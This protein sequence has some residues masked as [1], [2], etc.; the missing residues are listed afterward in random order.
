[1]KQPCFLDFLK[2]ELINS[3][4]SKR[5][6]RLLSPFRYRTCIFGEPH[7][8]EVPQGFKTDFAS[9]PRFPGAWWIA[10]A[11]AQRPAVVHDY[12]YR[13]QLVSRKEADQIFLEA[14]Q[15]DGIGWTHRNLMYAAVR[16]G[17]RAAYN[18]ERDHG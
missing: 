4:W 1:M 3:S 7:T 15:C 9:V 11:T 8:F 5:T 6:W 2:V 14:M 10:G 13:T 17:G 18:K 12:L 16:L